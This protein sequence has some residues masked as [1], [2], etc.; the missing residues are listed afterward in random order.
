LNVLIR[1]L[2]KTLIEILPFSSRY[3]PHVL[4]F[5]PNNYNNIMLLI[6]AHIDHV[7]MFIKHNLFKNSPGEIAQVRE[8]F[9]I[10]I[11]TVQSTKVVWPSS[12]YNK[13]KYFN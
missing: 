6:V 4:L 10:K 2:S 3:D 13:Y 12:K 5:V 1:V 9:L 11:L 8:L 7:F